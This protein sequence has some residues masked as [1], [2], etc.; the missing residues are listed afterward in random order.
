MSEGN[1]VTEVDLRLAL[2][3]LLERMNLTILKF[4]QP[5]VGCQN[6]LPSDQSPTGQSHFGVL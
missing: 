5:P 4:E 2:E 6:R 3:K 1:D